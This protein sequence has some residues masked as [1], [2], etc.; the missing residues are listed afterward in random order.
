[1][2]FSDHLF[3]YFLNITLYSSS[4]ANDFVLAPVPDAIECS[5]GTRLEFVGIF[6]HSFI[7]FVDN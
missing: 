7:N 2:G 6:H 1:M 5:I 3:K 4:E